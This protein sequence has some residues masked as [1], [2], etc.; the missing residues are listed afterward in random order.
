MSA[1]QQWRK[2]KSAGLENPNPQQQTFTD[3]GSFVQSHVVN[4]NEV[5][6]LIDANSP[7]G[8]AVIM[9]FLDDCRLFDLMHD[10]LPDHQPTTYQC[11][12]SKIDHIWGTPG[13]LTAMQHAGVLPFSVGPNS[14]HAILFLDLSFE[15]L[16]GISS[17]SLY[18]PTHPRFCNLWSTDIKAA[19]QYLTF[20]QQGFHAENIHH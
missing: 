12:Y 6:I 17:Q 13:V 9:M 19:E 10:Y 3:L 15:N 8:N 18:D 20:I 7:T 4:G 2:L 16:S 11:G 5:L 14:D 1:M